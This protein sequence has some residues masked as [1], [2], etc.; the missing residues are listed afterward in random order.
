[1]KRDPRTSRRRFLKQ[2]AALSGAA[3]GSRILG[4]PSILMAAAPN[5]R[6]NVAGIG[7]GGE[8]T[9]GS[10]FIPPGFH[11]G[12]LR[13]HG[14]AP[15][16]SHCKDLGLIEARAYEQLTCFEAGVMLAR[17]EGVV[18]APESTHAIRAAIDEALRCK[19]EGVSRAILFNLSGHGHFDMQAYTDYFAGK[20]TDIHYDESALQEAMAE[21]PTVGV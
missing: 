3:I 18:P 9:L 2:T 1:M 7:V 17:S 5:E 10:T 8:W 19:Q 20:L 16:V 11:A 14:M 13:Y 4:A 15:M 12:G 6:L 21:L